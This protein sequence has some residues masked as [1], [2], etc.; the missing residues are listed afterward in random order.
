M[1]RAGVDGILK[2]SDGNLKQSAGN[3]GQ[4]DGNLK[5]PDGN[6][7]HLYCTPRLHCNPPFIGRKRATGMG[8]AWDWDR[9]VQPVL[10]FWIEES[11]GAG[12]HV[13]FTLANYAGPTRLR[14]PA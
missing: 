10:P 3:L 13:A 6:L 1:G 5:Q 7:P 14:F 12:S 11:V 9:L 8:G 2:Q 4:S